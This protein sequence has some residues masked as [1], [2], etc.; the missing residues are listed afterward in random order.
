MVK[1]SKDF[2]NQCKLKSLLCIGITSFLQASFEVFCSRSTAHEDLLLSHKRFRTLCVEI[3]KTI[4][5]FNPLFT[6]KKSILKGTT[7]IHAFLYKQHFYKQH[8]AETAK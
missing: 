2:Q 3:F 4:A 7:K 5:Y 8:Q 1:T 6:K